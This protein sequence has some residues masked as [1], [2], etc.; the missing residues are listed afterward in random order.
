[1]NI[2]KFSIERRVTTLVLTFVML[3]VGLLSYD[4]LSRLEDPEF[5]IKEA[6]IITSYP[7]ASAAEVE[8]EV[9]DRL[10]KA[11]QQMGQLKFIESKSDRGLSTITVTIKDKYQKE[12]LQQVWDEL[13]RKIGDVQ[14]Q[15]PPGAGTSVVVDDYGDVYGIFVAIYGD[16][17]SYAEI[18]DV[19]DMLRKELL[20]V[21]D[22]GKVDTFGERVES[23]YVELN[24]DRMSQLG[25][26]DDAIINE[27][28]QKNVVTDAGRVKVGSEFITINPT[29]EV[30]SVKQFESILISSGGDEQ[31]YLRDVANVKRGY[32]DPQDHLIRYDGREAIGL[33]ISTVAGGNVV[34]MGEALEARLVE[35][36]GRIPV[37]IEAGVVSLQSEAVTMAINGFVSSLLQA[38]AIVIVVLLFFMG[39]RSGI[40]IGFVLMVT[41]AGTFIFMSPMEIALERISLGALIIALGM[42]VDNAIVIVDGVLVR[43]EK[44]ID[45]KKGSIE[46]VKQTAVPLL[47][48]TIIAILAFAAIGTSDDNTGEFCRSLFQVVMISLL[49]SWVTAVTLTPLLCVMFLKQTNGNKDDV[50]KDPYNGAVYTVYKKILQ[51]AI[52]MKFVTL[53]LV[54]ALFVTSLWGFGFVKQSFFPPSTRPQFMVDIW[55]P[56]GT[57]INETV[58]AVAAVE[59]DI[60]GMEGITHVTSLVG[61][62]GLRFLLTYSPEKTN[63]AYAQL[64]VDVESTD[65]M[66]ELAIQVED[67]L[68]ENYEDM[69]GYT[70][71]F[72]LGPGSTGKIQARFSGPDRNVLRGLA[73]QTEAIY[74]ADPDAKGI[75][76]DWRQRVKMVRPV[77]AEEQANLNG[78]TRPDI[79]NTLLDGFEGRTIGVYRE[80]DLLLPIILRAEDRERNNIDSMG[81][82]QIWSPAAEAR[83][84]LRQ[85]V[86]GFE[87]VF[88][89]EIIQR[90]NR[91]PTITVFADPD[92]GYATALYAR[93]APQ[94][95]ALEL[96]PGYE[97]EWGGEYEDSAN[98][99]AGLS[100]GLP[101]FFMCMVLIT[102]MLFN[103]LKQP[104]IIW[105]TVPLAVIGVTAGLL[106]SSQPFG[107]M[108]LLGI[109]SLSGMLIK[110]AIVLIDEINYQ[111]DVGTPLIA[112]IVDSGASRLRP[113]GMAASTTALGMIPLLFDAFFVSMAITI[114]AGLI[115]A[116]LLTM[117]VVPV[118]YATFYR[119]EAA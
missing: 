15:L 78:I 91:K 49:L 38:V 5:T 103:S 18:K 73:E 85:V 21:R 53:A 28:R 102:I 96:P 31:I 106:L 19:V 81:D 7:G 70:S 56:Q 13:R 47:G 86:S 33:G 46:I 32:V 25:I 69:L 67:Y 65:V 35:L 27:L 99:Q 1:M 36:R 60:L 87:T 10:E 6:L 9:T 8:E 39:L 76:T 84:P 108:A 74:R 11:A 112:A 57:H 95:E 66:D 115:F 29:G 71:K 82:L 63:S 2:A 88:E 101:V 20:L 117:I 40:L 107:F 89:D 75:R 22:V 43:L 41:I 116:T 97:L 52:R 34:K 51:A 90:R 72:Q 24:R 83:I 44:G 80:G 58:K 59:K 26:S 104:L 68:N 3:G 64:M 23:V 79:A 110:N 16:G 12:D 77:L 48:A 61:K 62:G 93:V 17:Y 98:A 100:A 54:V 37:G 30:T 45:A 50:D 118:L 42:L 55:L 109:L 4:G 14:E 111:V 105:L 114:I 94:V 92:E 119:E 113:V